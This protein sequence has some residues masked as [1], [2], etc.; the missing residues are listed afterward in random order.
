MSDEWEC[1]SCEGAIF[2]T[3]AEYDAHCEK[4]GEEV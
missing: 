4:H 1:E 3:E 2:E